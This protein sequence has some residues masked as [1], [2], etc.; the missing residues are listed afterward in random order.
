MSREKIAEKLI[1]AG[2][3][4]DI[5]YHKSYYGYQ[6]RLNKG[7]ETLDECVE[8]AEGTEC[9]E[10]SEV[11]QIQRIKYYVEECVEDEEK[12]LSDIQSAVQIITNGLAMRICNPDDFQ[13]YTPEVEKHADLVGI[14]VRSR[15]V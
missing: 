15:S 2:H 11:R 6:N 7:I 12:S 4:I 1:G 8:L 10:T 13:G 9:L 14:Q 5:N 3:L